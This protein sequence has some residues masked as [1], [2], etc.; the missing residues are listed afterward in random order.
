MV[1]V[2]AM[3]VPLLKTPA[4]WPTPVVATAAMVVLALLDGIGAVFAKQWVT[5]GSRA[6]FAAGMFAFLVLFWVYASSLRYAEL[7][8]VTFGWI[9]LLQVGLLCADHFHYGVHISLDKWLAAAGIV[10]LQAYLL[11]APSSSS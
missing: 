8:T 2:L 4:S 1:G 11:L 9:V 5:T 10:A 6:S 7:S 3:D